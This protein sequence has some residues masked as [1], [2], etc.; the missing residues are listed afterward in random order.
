MKRSEINQLIEAAK[1]LLHRHQ[2]RLPPFAY[3][4]PADW[5]KKGA[6]CDEIRQ[7]RLGWDITDFGAGDFEKMGL[8]VF[9]VRNGHR[10]LAPYTG[11]TYCEK[12]LIVREDQI[13]PMHY[14]VF[15]EE[16]IICRSGG[17]L[18][19]QVYNKTPGGQL[20]DTEVEVSLDGVRRRVKAGHK[21]VLKPGE[22]ITLT[23]LLWHAFWAERGTG[24]SIVGEVSKVN[25]D[26]TDNFFLDKIGRFPKIEEDAPPTHL[27]CTEYNT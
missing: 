18:V 26:A 11:K 7:C 6:E 14:H 23:P 13:T 22:S 21:F 17:S 1:S 15:K 10:T 20:A 16:D 3:W 9:T 2:M 4:S 5:K 27:L 24:L 25:D 12:I 19:C 8:V